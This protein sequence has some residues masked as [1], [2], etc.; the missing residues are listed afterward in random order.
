[1][2]VEN[3][4]AILAFMWR[5]FHCEINLYP[6]NVDTLV[7]IACVLHNFLL[8]PSENQR[9]LYED[10]QLDEP[11]SSKKHGKKQGIKRSHSLQDS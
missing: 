9:L 2:V 8:A 11:H 10:K 7:V 4:L 1:M 6:L 3:P 5:F